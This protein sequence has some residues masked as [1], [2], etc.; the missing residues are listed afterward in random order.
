MA[1]RRALTKA[2]TKAKE[3]ILLSKRLRLLRIA[4]II[5]SIAVA[6]WYLILTPICWL[7]DRSVCRPAA[8]RFMC[9][10][11]ICS[12]NFA[13]SFSDVTCLKIDSQLAQSLKS[14]NDHFT[15]A[16]LNAKPLMFL[17]VTLLRTHE[18]LREAR[19]V[20]QRTSLPSRE[21]LAKGIAHYYSNPTRFR[22]T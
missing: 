20:T 13:T 8:T 21:F 1:T 4:V 10:S 15:Q 7:A 22:V 18:A 14:T 16:V 19:W 17:S 2:S 12:I 3:A 11:N 9:P 6:V 5:G